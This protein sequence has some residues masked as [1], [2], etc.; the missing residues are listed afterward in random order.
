MTSLL[1]RSNA[2][3]E[4]HQNFDLTR[5]N[6]KKDIDGYE[7]DSI[8]KNIQE[9]FIINPKKNKELRK[10]YSSALVKLLKSFL[11]N[12]KTKHKEFNSKLEYLLLWIEQNYDEIKT[13]NET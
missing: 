9:Y 11:K 6:E 10:K 1:E 2:F 4:K 5:P 13:S 8:E 7:D 3:K 12:G